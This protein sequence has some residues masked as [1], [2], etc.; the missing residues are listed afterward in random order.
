MNKRQT[1]DEAVA[2]MR[3]ELSPDTAKI[4][5]YSIEKNHDDQAIMQKTGL[6]VAI[7]NLLAEHGIV[8]EEVVLYSVWFSILQ[9]AIK[10]ILE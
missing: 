5:R 7:R 10:T 9:E 4:I 1:F 3:N 8:W 2:I 6:G